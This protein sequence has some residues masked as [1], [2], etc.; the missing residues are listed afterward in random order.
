MNTALVEK[1]AILPQD[2]RMTLTVAFVLGGP[3]AGKGTQC[4]I[5]AAT[6]R[7]AHLSL[8]DV[9]REETGKAESEIGAVIAEC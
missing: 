1:G 8:G 4:A 3:G 6:D 5:L 7:F 9:M 2:N